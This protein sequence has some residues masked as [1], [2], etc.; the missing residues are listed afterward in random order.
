MV[1]II[2]GVYRS[3]RLK[4]L[5]GMETRPTSDRLKETLFNVLQ[6][7]LE[8]AVFLDCFAGS[9]N[10]GLEALSRGAASVVFVESSSKAAGIIRGNF[11]A[12]HL[13][14]S[15]K[16]QLL[17]CP[18][19]KG[20]KILH[21][22]GRKFDIVFLDPPY[23]EV[24]SYLKVFQQVAAL[25]LLGEGG[26]VIAEHSKHAQIEWKGSGLECFREIRQGDS[27]LSLLKK[28]GI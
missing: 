19:E 12:L 8:G 11:E 17:N 22:A 15:E 26:W 25:D 28:E 2:A 14:G 16:I 27:R 10:I 21:Q 9:G 4:T 3:R 5:E 1:R 23:R 6:G 7:R 24:P 13:Q 18:V 20:L